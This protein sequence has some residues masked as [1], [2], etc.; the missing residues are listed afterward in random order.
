MET[1]LPSNG[2]RRNLSVWYRLDAASVYIAVQK[3]G[4]TWYVDVD[5]PDGGYK[6]WDGTEFDVL[7]RLRTF[8]A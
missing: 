7:L 2:F 5:Y 4:N 1:Y 3:I 8:K 6:T